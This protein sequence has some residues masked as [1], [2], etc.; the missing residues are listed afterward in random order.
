MKRRGA[1]GRE[2]RRVRDKE[3]NTGVV[4]RYET[5]KQKKLAITSRIRGGAAQT[6]AGMWEFM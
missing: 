3:G 1:K 6:K 5:E 2:K 4:R